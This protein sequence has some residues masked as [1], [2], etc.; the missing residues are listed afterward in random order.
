MRLFTDVIRQ[1]SAEGQITLGAA[2]LDDVFVVILLALL[3]EF[4]VTGEVNLANAT[5]VLVFVSAFF[6]V[7]VGLS[8]DLRHIDWGS[9]FFWGLSLTRV[10]VAI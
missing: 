7:T 9:L 6:F 3:Y 1:N 4:S 2:V 8:L 5:K 10:T